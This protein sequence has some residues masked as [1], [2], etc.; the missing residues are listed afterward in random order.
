MEINWKAK[1]LAPIEKEI[2]D[3][4]RQ[5]AELALKKA[6][7]EK[8]LSLFKGVSGG[9]PTPVKNRGGRPKKVVAP[10]PEQNQAAG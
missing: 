2:A 6:A 10:P 8:A 1:A 9:A 7:F 4:D 5:M 3:L